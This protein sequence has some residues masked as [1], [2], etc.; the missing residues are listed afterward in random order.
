MQEIKETPFYTR[1]KPPVGI[2]T[3]VTGPSKTDASK[4]EETDVYALMAKYGVTHSK[5][6]LM[7]KP[8]RELFI[9][10]TVVPKNMTLM[11]AVELKNEFVDYFEKAPARFRKVFHDNPDEFYLAYKQGEYDKLLNSGAL[12]QEQ[13]QIQKDA[14]KAELQPIQD[15]IIQ[16]E[17]QLNEERLKNER[18]NALINAQQ[19]TQSSETT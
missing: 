18:L 10:T 3:N 6:G 1:F 13:I 2:V 8:E 4:M 12:T 7:T 14:I 5:L 16:Y 11:E 15:K 9:D 17:T 19:N